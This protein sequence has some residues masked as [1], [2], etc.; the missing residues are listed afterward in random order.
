[1]IVLA[2]DLARRTGWA[3]G[4]PCGPVSYGHWI[5]KDDRDERRFLEMTRL[6]TRLLD[7]K[8]ATM[9]VCEAP[10]VGAGQRANTLMPLFGFRAA[11]Y[12]AAANKGI[13]V[14]DMVTPATVRKH[15]IGHGGLA[16]AKAK[17]AVIE[18]CQWRGWATRDEDEADALALWDYQC[19]LL[20]TQHFTMGMRRGAFI[21]QEDKDATSDEAKEGA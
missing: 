18:K 6:V 19:A 10:F 4:K 7:E 9:L 2:L 5:I 8:G 16:R 1:M 20:D 21:Q 17:K 11:A 12:I 14:A 13:R 3:A 15:F